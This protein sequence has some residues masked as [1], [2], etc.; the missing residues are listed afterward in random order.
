M[1]T[2][3]S[4]FSKDEV[5]EAYARAGAD[6]VLAR[7]AIDKLFSPKS[8]GWVWGFND[9]FLDMLAALSPDAA[10]RVEM[11]RTPTEDNDQAAV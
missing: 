1:K 10:R 2:L 6:P 4:L 11:L 3:Q 8:E 7:Q 9:T 5:A